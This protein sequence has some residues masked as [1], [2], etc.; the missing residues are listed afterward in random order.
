M[1]GKLASGVKIK[2]FSGI[3]TLKFNSVYK[4]PWTVFSWLESRRQNRQASNLVD[5][6][7]HLTTCETKVRWG[8]VYTL[9]CGLSIQPTVI[10]FDTL[11]DGE[12]IIKVQ[13][14]LMLGQTVF[15]WQEPKIRLFPRRSQSVVDTS[16]RYCACTRWSPIYLAAV[17]CMSPSTKR[18]STTCKNCYGISTTCYLILYSCKACTEDLTKL[19]IWIDSSTCSTHPLHKPSSEDSVTTKW[20]CS[21]IHADRAPQQLS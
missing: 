21:C 3:T 16:Q 4:P 11:G 2:D 1:A 19:Y 8:E 14:F 15:V 10:I 13:N 7:G 18:R 5:P 9:I 20:Y 12:N 17:P 6:F